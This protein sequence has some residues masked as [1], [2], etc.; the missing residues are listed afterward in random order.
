MLKVY[1]FRNFS[2]IQ[3]KKLK[4]FSL[5]EILVSLAL[6]AF[7]LTIVVG[8]AIMLVNAQKRVQADIFLTQSAQV[9]LENLSRNLRFGYN[10]SG[11]TFSSYQSSPGG[12]TVYVNAED[13]STNVG[14][15][16]SSSQLLTNALNSP[17]VVFESQNGNPTDLS[18]QQAYCFAKDATGNNKIY[19]IE[20]FNVETNNITYYKKCSD[21]ESLLPEKVNLDYIVF[22]VYGQ[23]STAPKNPMIR[24][25]LKLTHVEG[26]SVE[27]QTTITQRLIPYF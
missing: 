20:G 27:M 8:T 4:T 22:D 18:D 5:I 12:E 10:Y 7:I 24:I 1:F 21:G 23:S 9:T 25:K 2:K 14:S 19:K 6:F 11:S 16:A 13:V 3:N 26:G 15:V 17:F